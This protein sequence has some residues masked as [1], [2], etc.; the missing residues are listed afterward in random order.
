MNN[1]RGRGLILIALMAIGG[2]IVLF[3]KSTSQSNNSQAVLPAASIKPASASGRS[4]AQ[5]NRPSRPHS[6]TTRVADMTADEKSELAKKFSEKFQPAVEQ[7][8]KAYGDHIPFRPEDFTLEKFHSRLG[9][10]MYTFMIT[11]DLTF[12]I[13]DSRDPQGAAKV[14][15]LMSRKAAIEMNQVPGKGFV[16]DLSVPISR[17]EVIRMVQAN[18]GVEFKPN[19]VLIIPT[20]KSCALNGGVYVNIIP[21]GLDPNNGLNSKIILVVGPDGKLANYERAA[22]F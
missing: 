21:A 19:E 16:P 17:E 10:Y 12:T 2:L 11:P 4:S 15:Y 5:T 22:F 18:T 7:W 20:A 3:W 14:S 13:Q 8:F 9:T 1:A 6:F